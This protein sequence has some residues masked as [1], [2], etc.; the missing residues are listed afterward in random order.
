MQNG[1][2]AIEQSYNRHDTMV[3]INYLVRKLSLN[4]NDFLIYQTQKEQLAVDY[5]KELQMRVANLS[6]IHFDIIDSNYYHYDNFKVNFI[7]LKR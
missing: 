1:I 2:D 5:Q 6:T 4:S 3:D 7:F